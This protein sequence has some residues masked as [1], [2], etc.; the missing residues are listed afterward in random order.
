MTVI[1][2]NASTKFQTNLHVFKWS[3]IMK[4]NVLYVRAYGY[5]CTAAFVSV[6]VR[7]RVRMCVDVDFQAQNVCGFPE[8][9]EIRSLC[10][11]LSPSLAFAYTVLLRLFPAM[12]ELLYLHSDRSTKFR[13]EFNFCWEQY[14]ISAWKSG[15]FSR[16]ESMYDETL[17]RCINN[18][19]I[20]PEWQQHSAYTHITVILTTYY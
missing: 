14:N 18:N 8:S 20:L 17:A 1:T 19:E 15:R 13:I 3:L 9:I 16:C 12:L 2:K 10:L 5:L 6:L 11:S 4:F 7:V